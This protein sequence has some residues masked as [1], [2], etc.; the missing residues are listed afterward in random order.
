MNDAQSLK[1]MNDAPM[2]MSVSSL[3]YSLKKTSVLVEIN[4]FPFFTA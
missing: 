3:K 4:I 2:K 1:L